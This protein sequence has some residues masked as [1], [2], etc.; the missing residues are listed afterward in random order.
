MIKRE[1]SFLLDICVEATKQERNEKQLQN[2]VIY[3]YFKKLDHSIKTLFP[4]IQQTYLLITI[5]VL[6]FLR[7]SM[8][9]AVLANAFFIPKQG[10]SPNYFS[11]FLPK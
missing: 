10:F 5:A 1:T 8:N 4:L 7:A 6:R 9:K 2:Y 11:T 3:C